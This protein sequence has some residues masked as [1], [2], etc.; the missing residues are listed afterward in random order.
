M[1]LLAERPWPRFLFKWQL[2]HFNVKLF[3][4]Q[5]DHHSARATTT[6]AASGLWFPGTAWARSASLRQIHGAHR[7]FATLPCFSEL[8]SDCFVPI[9]SAPPIAGAHDC[10][11]VTHSGN[12]TT[13]HWEEC[14]SCADTTTTTVSPQ[15]AGAARFSPHSAA[16]GSPSPLQGLSEVALTVDS[17]GKISIHTAHV[18]VE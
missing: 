7:A 9:S 10:P 12:Q 5:C 18:L 11:C 15:R 16:G 2:L 8:V 17:E 14:C 4:W 1:L 6:F 13:G 3:H